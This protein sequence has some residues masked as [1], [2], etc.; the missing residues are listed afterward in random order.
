MK[1]IFSFKTLPYSLR[2]RIKLQCKSTKTICGLTAISSLELNIWAI[3]PPL[4][5]NIK[6]SHEFMRKIRERSPKNCTCRLC[7]IYIQ[8]IG[9]LQARVNDP[10]TKPE[11]VDWTRNLDP[12]LNSKVKV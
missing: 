12:R 2:N 1:N 4:M 11:P 3:L 9:F 10:K 6:S 7:K 5:R 8:N